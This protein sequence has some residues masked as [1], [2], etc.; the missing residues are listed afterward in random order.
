MTTTTTLTPWDF[1]RDLSLKLKQYTQMPEEQIDSLVNV[2]LGAVRDYT[3]SR[4]DIRKT[5]ARIIKTAERAINN[6][7]QG[8]GIYTNDD[9][10][11]DRDRLVTLHAEC[12]RY[13][14]QVHSVMSLICTVTGLSFGFINAFEYIGEKD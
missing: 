6:I 5:Y 3:E 7:D 9:L 12:A 2:A 1:G 4:K 13:Q 8:Y 14:A 10:G 11:S